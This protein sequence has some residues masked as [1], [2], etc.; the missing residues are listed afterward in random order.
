MDTTELIE[1]LMR[2]A[3]PVRRLASPGLRA[4]FWLGIALPY[5][6]AV[7][8]I[9]SPRSDLLIQLTDSRLMLEQTAAFATAILAAVAAFGMTV[10]GRN[11]RVWL[12]PVLPIVVWFI[13]LGKGCLDD[14]ARLGME[15]LRL[16]ADWDCLPP[17]IIAGVVPAIAMVAMLRRGAPLYPKA[18][19]AMGALAVAALANAGLQI[20]H[21]EDISIMVLVWHFGFV[22]LLSA[23]FA[24][25]GPL[26]LSWPR[27]RS[28]A[29]AARSHIGR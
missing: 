4:A 6:A 25:T 16:R 26:V 2:G 17:A 10:P 28:L 3:T 5:V 15:G 23:L 14:W 20:Y 18:T 11:R 9:L 21:A 27:P 24:M 1:R 7:V 8:L 22:F 13:S 29:S 19:V 12:L